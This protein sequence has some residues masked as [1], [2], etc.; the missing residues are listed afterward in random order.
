MNLILDS[1]AYSAW[2]QKREI[3]LEN[4]CDFILANQQYIDTSVNLD[5]IQPG[6]AEVAAAAGRQNFLRMRERGILPMPVFHARERLKWLDLM[7]NECPYVGLSATSLVSP[8]EARAWSRLT[9]TY[10]TDNEGYPISKFHAFGDV[11]P[12]SMLTSPHYSSDA[13]TWMI[14]G[15]RAGRVK[16]QGKSYQLRSKSIG[17]SSYI[18]T[19]DS[20][21]KRESWEY[22]IRELG[23]DPEAVMNVKAK[24]SELAMI[25]SY[26]VAADLL[27]L[28]EQ[29]R[30][31]NKFLKPACLINTKKQQTGGYVREGPIRFYFV[32]SPSA[33]NFN[34]PVLCALGIKDILVSYFYIVTASKGFWEEKLIPF[35]NDPEAFCQT[36][37]KTKRFY[38]KLNEVLLKPV[39][40]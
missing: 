28:Q 24:G 19:T 26:L 36:D 25:R 1:G 33:Y 20:G 2:T 12:Y 29:T 10:V 39:S 35:L 7:I 6:D 17:D 21:L 30:Y 27:Q 32:I 8:L 5:V 22:E 40:V 15:G 37:P 11:A 16:L 38:D 9:W 18:S 34:F 14:M 4:Y 3:S 23:L 13:A 31:I